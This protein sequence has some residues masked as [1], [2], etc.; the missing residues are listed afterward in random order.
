LSQ[1]TSRSEAAVTIQYVDHK[2]AEAIL[3]S[4]EPDNLQLPDGIEIMAEAVGDVLTVR[5]ECARGVGSM[6]ATLDDLLSCVQA[7]E[8]AIEEL[9]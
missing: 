4:I 5:I 3:S 9:G 7:A 8:R 6:V 2:T 1:S